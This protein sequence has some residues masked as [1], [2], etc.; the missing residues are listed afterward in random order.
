MKTIFL[1]VFAPTVLD[2]DDI[3]GD[4]FVIHLAP[5]VRCNKWKLFILSEFCLEFYDGILKS[6][7]VFFLYLGKSLAHLGYGNEKL[8]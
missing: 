1:S 3:K 7:L 2:T 4:K 8:F 6:M 5:C